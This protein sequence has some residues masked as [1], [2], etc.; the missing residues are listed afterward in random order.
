MSFQSEKVKKISLIREKLLK[1]YFKLCGYDIKG[2][3]EYSVADY[4]LFDQADRL[5]SVIDLKTSSKT[6]NY[7]LKRYPK[8]FLIDL[9]KVKNLKLLSDKL[10]CR[11]QI[12]VMYSDYE[13][14]YIC[15]LTDEIINSLIP[16]D[17]YRKKVVD[18]DYK[19]F[20]EHKLYSDIKEQIYS[21]DHGVLFK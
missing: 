13:N 5:F 12:I 7:S 2:T 18:L 15:N 14:F 1:E 11:A 4:M 21:D 17:L 9:D 19:L 6:R 8:G 16:R 3:T 20:T 10:K